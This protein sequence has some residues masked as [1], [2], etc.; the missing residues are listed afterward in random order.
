MNQINRNI[1]NLNSTHL[2]NKLIF[3]LNLVYLIH[4][5]SSTNQLLN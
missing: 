2:V 5:P 4:K 1:Y 3:N